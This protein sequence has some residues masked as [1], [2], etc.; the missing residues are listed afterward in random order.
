[1][2]PPDCYRTAKII[3]QIIQ[4]AGRNLPLSEQEAA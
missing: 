1:M 3:Q 4:Y 2:F